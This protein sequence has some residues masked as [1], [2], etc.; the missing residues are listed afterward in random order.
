MILPHRANPRGCDF[1][2]RQLSFHGQ[3]SVD[4]TTNITESDFRYGQLTR[5]QPPQDG[6]SAP[7]CRR[8]RPLP[9]VEP[10][11]R[12]QVRVTNAVIF[13]NRLDS[14]VKLLVSPAVWS[15]SSET[16]RPELLSA[17]LTFS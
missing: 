11:E 2:E 4:F 16:A 6:G 15:S 1:R 9:A 12:F 14:D 7:R 8:E 5:L 10:D 17:R 13:R 3:F